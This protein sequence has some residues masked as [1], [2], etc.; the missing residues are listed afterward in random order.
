MCGRYS[1]FTEQANEE[2]LKLMRTVREKCK[3][4]MV[5]GEIFPANL[6]P[7]FREAAGNAVLELMKWGFP[8]F[9]KKGGVIINARAETVM[10]KPM[11]REA[12]FTG[13]CAIPS[14]GF[15]EWDKE[16]AKYKF[17]LP[18]E[19]TLYM[20]GLWNEYD[21]ERRFV[22][23]TAAANQSMEEIH[24]RM[25]LVL[26]KSQI[27]NWLCNTQKAVKLLNEVPPELVKIKV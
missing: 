27:R 11:F 3:E 13:R 1:L 6:V 24:S 4:E 25:P 15:Y 14:T 26:R 23:L 21:K 2:I 19:D 16:K 9:Y 8:N 7:V 20:A 22:I 18:Q 12:V 10:E 5:H 17:N